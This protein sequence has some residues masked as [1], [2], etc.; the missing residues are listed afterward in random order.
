MIVAS[1]DALPID[2][3][4][5]RA[6]VLAERAAKRLFMEERDGLAAERDALNAANE[7]LQHIIAVLRRP[8][9]SRFTSASS[10]S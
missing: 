5:L 7:K 1:P 3:N 9:C 6:M 10:S 4:G 8:N 2:V